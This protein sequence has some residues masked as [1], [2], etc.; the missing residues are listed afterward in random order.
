MKNSLN[1]N[2]KSKAR[3]TFVAITFSF[4]T[5]ILN[6]QVSSKIYGTWEITNMVFVAPPLRS[7]LTA[8]WKNCHRRRIVIRQ[9]RFIFNASK[10]FLYRSVSN[11]NITAEFDLSYSE[12]IQKD[13]YSEKTLYY[14]FNNHRRTTLKALKTSYTFESNEG[15]VPELEIFYLDQ[16]H[17]IINQGENIVFLKRIR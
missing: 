16:N 6:A 3:S 9:H 12:A 14:L 10:C 15:D 11:F 4:L 5:G 8:I 17:L 2:L 7:E 13:L 1:R